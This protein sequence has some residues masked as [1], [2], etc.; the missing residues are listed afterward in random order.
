M[1][2]PGASGYVYMASCLTWERFMLCARMWTPN[3]DRGI[4][5]CRVNPE[6]NFNSLNF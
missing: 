1:G 2:L 6:S 3:T 4:V 5:E